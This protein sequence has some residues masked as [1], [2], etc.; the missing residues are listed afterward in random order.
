MVR[1]QLGV[2]S[3]DVLHDALRLNTPLTFG[4]AVIVVSVAVVFGSFVMGVKPGAGTVANVILVGTFTDAILFMGLLDGIPSANLPT[5]LAA[6]LIG[7]MTIA[8]AT[9]LYI[10]AGLGAGPRDSLMLAAA[11]RLLVSTGTSRALIE[12]SVLIVGAL[13][14][15]KLGV[16]T[17]V[18]AVAIGPAINISFR[19]FGMEPTRQLTNRR[20]R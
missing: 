15:G 10:S 18:F 19:L 3:W 20:G 9:A 6:L 14:G 17:A 8:V 11:R 4:A 16:G 7:V 13:L 1:A 2:S 5:R 12:G